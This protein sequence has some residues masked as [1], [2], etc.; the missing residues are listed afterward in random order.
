MLPS[1]VLNGFVF[2]LFLV[3]LLVLSSDWL[4]LRPD[5]VVVDL[6]VVE[7]RSSPVV[8]SA[9]VAEVLV[10]FVWLVSLVVSSVSPEVGV[11]VAP[12]DV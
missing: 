8:V 4:K 10:V 9:E 3:R 7:L 5:D 1:I 11:C 12:R 6:R 2:K